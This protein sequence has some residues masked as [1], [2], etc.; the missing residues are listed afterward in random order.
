MK[1]SENNEI[2]VLLKLRARLELLLVLVFLR[3]ALFLV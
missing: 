2:K 3:S 1:T